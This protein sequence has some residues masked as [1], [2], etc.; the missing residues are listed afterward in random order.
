MIVIAGESA[1]RLMSDEKT[2]DA[3]EPAS[4]SALGS[5][6]R[7]RIGDV[8]ELREYG[9]FATKAEPLHILVGSKD[10]RI[11]SERVVNHIWGSRLPAASLCHLAPGVA[12]TSP[13]FCYLLAGGRGIA[14]AAAVGIEAC[15]AYGRDGSSR[16]FADR[17]AISSLASLESYL[18]GARGCRGVKAAR[19]ALELVVEGSR[20]PLETKTAVLLTAPVSCGGYGIPSPKSNWPVWP[21]SE[22]LS[23]F[24]DSYYLIDLCWPDKLVSLECDSYAYHSSKDER[25]DDAKK[26]NALTSIGWTCL[27]ATS[28]QL[29]G[30]AL[31]TLAK[32]VCAALGITFQQ[33]LA[34]LRDSLVE[35]VK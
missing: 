23:L 24:Y 29:S 6:S 28:G 34:S 3:L 2:F 26:R 18:C 11:Q 21:T 7:A 19:S 9:I 16:G 12:L 13:E 22:Q 8:D 14:P 10:D 4:Q 20:S 35:S 27:T 17:K 31:D 1:M 33:P 5:W 30:S 25:D 32:Q 15:G